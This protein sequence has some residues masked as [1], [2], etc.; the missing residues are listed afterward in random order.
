MPFARLPRDLP[1]RE[2]VRAQAGVP[3]RWAPAS[4][5]LIESRFAI[6][7][8]E[9]M[10]EADPKPRPVAGLRATASNADCPEQEARLVASLRA[11]DPQAFEALVRQQGP[12]LLVVARRIVR[13][14]EDARDCVQEAF[15]AVHRSIGGFEARSRLGTWLRRIVTNAALM[16][17][18]TRLARPEEPIEHLLPR[19]D[20]YGYLEGPTDTNAA[21]AEE[22]L[23]RAGARQR[24]REA[25]ARLPD[26]YRVVLLLRDIEGYSTDEAARVLEI[27]PGAAKVRLHRARTALKGLLQE[28]F[29]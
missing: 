1:D 25:I 3:V 12:R 4:R 16:K 10:H 2:I 13:N 28:L 29:E 22:L 18:R 5:A 21:C 7:P 20:R 26:R 8:G 11:G 9:P 14:E 15:L 19:Y 23:D 27:S 17:I 6:L 24:V